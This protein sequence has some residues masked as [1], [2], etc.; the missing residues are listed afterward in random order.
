MQ[1][2]RMR[3]F[4]ARGAEAILDLVSITVSQ[5]FCQEV[6]SLLLDGVLGLGKHGKL[7]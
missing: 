3:R 6:V 2:R 1:K 7:G 4:V 5:C